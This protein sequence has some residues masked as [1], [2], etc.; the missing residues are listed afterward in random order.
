MTF[1]FLFPLVEVLVAVGEVVAHKSSEALEIHAVV[2]G[3]GLEVTKRASN[4]IYLLCGVMVNDI[5]V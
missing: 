2:I 4:G 1:G 5:L 3:N